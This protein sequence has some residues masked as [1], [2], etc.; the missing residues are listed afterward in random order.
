MPC[1][2]P[3]PSW[4][5][6]WPSRVSSGSPPRDSRCSSSGPSTRPG[7]RM[8]RAPTRCEPTTGFTAAARRAVGA[9]TTP[10]RRRGSGARRSHLDAR[11]ERRPRDRRATNRGRERRRCS[12]CSPT[13][14]SRRDALAGGED[15]ALLATFPP[16]V[17]LPGGF[18]P[19]GRVVDGAGLRIDGRDFDG[20]GGWDPFDGWNGGAVLPA[21]RRCPTGQLTPSQ[22][23]AVSP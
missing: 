18:R 4:A 2:V 23:R 12:S 9:P 6:S 3:A 21:S 20:R 5:T 11:R 19:I 7:S 13:R 17:P 16:G 10:R 1:C 8:P 14:S 15:H 22:Y